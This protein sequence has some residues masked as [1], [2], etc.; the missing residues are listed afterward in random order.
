M[1]TKPK[2]KTCKLRGCNAKF[3]PKNSFQTWCSPEHGYLIAKANKERLDKQADIK[4]RNETRKKKTELDAKKLL[5]FKVQ[6]IARLIDKGQP[7]L[8]HRNTPKQVH[9]GHVFSRGSNSSMAFNIHNI[10][11]QSAQ[12]NHFQADDTLMKE[13]LAREYGQEYFNFVS[14]LRRT[15][16]L[17]YNS[18]EYVEFLEKARAFA[19]DLKKKKLVYD[20]QDRIKLRNIANLTLGIY[21]KEFCVYEGA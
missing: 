7:C 8:A 18:I 17:T 10:H 5:Q 12:S 19:N 13:G 9:G 4:D 14:E 11:R 15:P 2:E 1:R 3:V 21:S 6:E 20:L 16:R